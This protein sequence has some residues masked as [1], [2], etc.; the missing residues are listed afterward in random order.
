MIKPHKYTNKGV[1]I[2]GLGKTGRSAVEF[3]SKVDANPIIVWDDDE[4]RI[5]GL[6][7]HVNLFRHSE[8]KWENLELLIPSPGIGSDHP[9]S[10]AARTAGCNVR[11]D[12]E[13]LW[14]N[15]PE[16]KYIG[17]TGTNGKSTTTALISHILNFSG[18]TNA[19]GGN[20]GTPALSLPNLSKDEIYILELSSFQLSLCNSLSFDIAALIN[21]SEDHLEWHGS[22]DAYIEAKLGIFRKGRLSNAI[23]GIDDINTQ[24]IYSKLVKEKIN[25]II[26]VS[27]NHI[28]DCGISFSNG[29][30]YEDGKRVC[31]IKKI[32]SLIGKHNA[33]NAAVAW[34]VVRAAGVSKESA[35]KGISDFPGLEHRMESVSEIHGVRFINDSKATNP[36]AAARALDT[37]SSIYWIAGGRAKCNDISPLKKSIKSVKHVF[38]FGESGYS[39]EVGLEGLTKSNR[40]VDLKSAIKAAAATAIEDS[41]PDAVVLF[42][43]AC[44]SFDQFDNF[45][46][47]GHAFK[48]HVSDLEN[49]NLDE[50]LRGASSE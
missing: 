50:L 26:P 24:K 20:F 40:F 5:Q 6:P 21:I 48:R 43:P 37:F 49:L 15:M 18:V 35:R 8:I 3:F 4:S 47:R 12:I 2:L 42:S 1:A 45:E 33:Q 38:L 14:E 29:F 36:E 22:L 17:I 19:V 32:P 23:I 41:E 9:M 11:S 39:L 31:C 25:N 16:A 30:L 13:V 10:I 34:A 7:S 27:S 44:S 46:D 28:I